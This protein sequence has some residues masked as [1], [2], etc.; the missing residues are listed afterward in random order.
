VGLAVL[1]EFAETLGN[2]LTMESEKV[3][4]ANYFE[5]IGVYCKMQTDWLANTDDA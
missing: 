2:H 3:E 1:N 4:M 5:S